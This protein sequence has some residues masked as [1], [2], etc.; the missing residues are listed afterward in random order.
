MMENSALA[1][2][3]GKGGARH[4]LSLYLPFTYKV[5][6]YTL[7]EREDTP[8]Y[9]ISILYV[10]CGCLQQPHREKENRSHRGTKRPQCNAIVKAREKVDGQCAR[11]QVAISH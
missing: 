3:G 4:P 2:E 11:V 8:P 1:G 5:V 7:A 6:V 10:L 9:F